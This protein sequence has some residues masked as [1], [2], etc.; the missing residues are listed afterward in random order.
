MTAQATQLT[1]EQLNLIYQVLETALSNPDFID[2][3][4]S[5]GMSPG[6][7]GDYRDDMRYVMDTVVQM[8][9]EELHAA[10]RAA[11]PEDG[12]DYGDLEVL[13]F[14]PEDTPD[15]STGDWFACG[16]VRVIVRD[17]GTITEVYRFTD[18]RRRALRASVTI[19]GALPA[20]VHRDIIKSVLSSG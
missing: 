14:A 5:G 3:T 15:G 10:A 9:A 17:G 19:D 13:G 11:A 6:E 1:G 4:S 7:A 8:T 18:D 12:T 2:T 20:T 16:P